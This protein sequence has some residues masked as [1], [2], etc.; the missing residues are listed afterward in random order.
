MN[1]LKTLK[2]LPIHTAIKLDDSQL[3]SNVNCG[4]LKQESIKWIKTIETESITLSNGL[5]ETVQGSEK[6][7][8]VKPQDKKMLIFWIKL[9]FNIT[10]EDLK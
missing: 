1:E 9:F 6:Y 8:L 7:Y 3:L 2:D 4:D 5:P 10:E